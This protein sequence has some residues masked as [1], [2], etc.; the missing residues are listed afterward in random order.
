MVVDRIGRS[1]LKRHDTDASCTGQSGYVLVTVMAILWLLML[2][3]IAV[4]AYVLTALGLTRVSIEKAQTVRNIDGALER[5]LHEVRFDPGACASLDLSQDD[6]RVVCPSQTSSDGHGQTVRII[7][8]EVREGVRSVGWA[9]VRVVDLAPSIGG[10]GGGDTP[11]PEVQI[12]HGF[13][14]EVC[15]WKLGPKQ[16]AETP[17]DCS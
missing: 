17:G 1:I 9:T 6:Y 14:V 12:T 5:G 10:G 3:T 7:G 15:D 13:S 4:V 2:I 16:V 8:L 11:P